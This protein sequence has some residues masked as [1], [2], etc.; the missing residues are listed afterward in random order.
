MLN[1]YTLGLD[2]GI[3]SVGWAV[4]N[5]DGAEARLENFGVRLFR[6]G[7]RNAGKDRLSQERR[8]Y[9]SERRLVRR[10]KHRKE[11]LKAYLQ[12]IGLTNL[13][14]IQAWYEKNNPQIYAIRAK[15]AYERLTGEEIAVALIHI[16]NHRGYRDFY[17]FTN[18]GEKDQ[19]DKEINDI[20]QAIS[21]IDE[22]YINGNYKTIGEMFH[23]DNE[24]YKIYNIDN[25][26]D[27][28]RLFPCTKNNEHTFRY[29]VNRTYLEHEV[30]TILSVQSQYYSCLTQQVKNKIVDI[31]FSQ[32]DFEDGPGDVN[33]NTR[34]YKGF[35]YSIGN[36][37]YYKNLPRG[38]RHTVISDIFAL[39]NALSQYSYR[40]LS[41]GSINL[42]CDAA[43]AMVN[44]A[45]TNAAISIKEVKTILKTFNIELIENSNIDKKA[46]IKSLKYLPYIKKA[47]ENVG[48]SWQEYIEED[49]FDK[50]NPSKLHL[51]GE[52]LSSYQTPRRRK[53]ELNKFNFVNNKLL[54]ILLAKKFSGTVQVSKDYMIDTIKAFLR[55]ET[56]GN[57]QARKIV[58]TDK[59]FADIK[60]VKSSRLPPI[61]DKEINQN[62]VVFRA[63]NETRKIVNALV[64]L[65]GLPTYINVEVAKELDRSFETREKMK[66]EHKKN[67]ELYERLKERCKELYDADKVNEVMLDKLRLYE[68][69]AGKC[70]YS[71]ISIEA[72]ELMSPMYQ[73]DHI[74]PYSLIL[75]NTIHNKALVLATENQ[76]KRQRTPLMY[77]DENKRN[78]FLA[79][80]NEDYRQKKISDKKYKYLTLQNLNDE[81]LLH[82]WKSRNINDTRYITKYI[83]NYMQ[84]NLIFNTEKKHSVYG[85]KSAVTSRFRKIWLRGSVWGA[86]EKDRQQSHF[87]HAVDAIVLAN[88]TP[89][90]IEIASDYLKLESIYRRNNKRETSEY[91]EYLANC[92]NKMLKYYGFKKDYAEKLLRGGKVPAL[93]P[94]IQAEIRLRLND[95]CT[96]DDYRSRAELFYRDRAFTEALVQPI[97]SA[98]P[99]RK[100]KGQI[101]DINPISVQEIDGVLWKV[102]R[103]EI[104]TLCHSDISKLVGASTDLLDKLSEVFI[105]K[106][107]KYTV[108]K[109]LKENNLDI[110]MTSSGHPVRKVS[111]KE[112]STGIKFTKHIDAKNEAVLN[113]K[114]HCIEIY[115][116]FDNNT[117]MQGIQ[118]VD[119]KKINGKLVL[120]KEFPQKYKEHIMY[121]FY[122][123]YI[124]I[125][126]K[127]NQL[128]AS[129]YYQGVANINQGKI[130]CVPSNKPELNRDK[131]KISL[132]K[133]DQIYKY[134]V[135]LLGRLGGEV[136]CGEQLLSVEVKN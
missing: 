30:A 59:L 21:V 53:K 134:D 40:D 27:K 64:G 89:E 18:F 116:D 81:A 4:I 125:Y 126:N 49:Q 31:I 102:K 65:Y 17:E 12:V 11:R 111:L 14:K 86:Q 91:L 97:V 47:L 92:Q 15:G 24:F 109:Y 82:E 121:I 41:N 115:K 114:Y 108:G 38:F 130:Y 95:E 87:H 112:A 135:S 136:K 68:L 100:Y 9:R 8:K 34:P 101:N 45:M 118:Y 96:L 13:D 106:E 67:E 122:N 119:L 6:S 66:K 46:L 103:K 110:L 63:I 74:V 83:I 57:F 55:G 84:R 37:R 36:C 48:F 75:D 5:Q 104:E 7:E 113:T 133:S 131:L 29:L 117:C 26:S 25:E 62:P 124:K 28:K 88:L 58:E 3:G 107:D 120:L 123:D 39:T 61:T 85:V 93:L 99:N 44:Y 78:E 60:G 132:S 127:R 23:K 50:N 52:V 2:L 72:D 94:R 43:E 16:A 77:M 56:Y 73:I 51:L 1:K 32:R 129:G 80:I 54:D 35:L 79:R 76:N 33:D 19:K 70:Y 20:K 71:G 90:Y 22:I 105:G 69:Q 10:R 128:K 42:S 98:K